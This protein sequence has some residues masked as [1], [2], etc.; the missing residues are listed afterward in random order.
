MVLGYLWNWFS[1]YLH[2]RQQHGNPIS[3]VLP[4]LS[5]VPQGSILG[6]LSFILYINDLPSLLKD[7]LPFLF[8]D[9]TKCIHAAKTT[10]DFNKNT[11]IAGNWQVIC[12]SIAPGVLFCTFGAT[13]KLQLNIFSTTILLI[14]ENQLKILGLW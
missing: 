3:E 14:Q 11:N 7:L 10:C 6:P 13:T 12:R 4:V 2:N 5:G 8:A 9:D 1:A